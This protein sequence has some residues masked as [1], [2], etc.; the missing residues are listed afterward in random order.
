MH[1][2]TLLASLFVCL[3]IAI[4][5]GK[6]S[7]TPVS[8]SGSSSG[9]AGASADGSTLKATAPT[10]QS[11]T[12]GARVEGGVVLRIGN[13][14]AKFAT[15]PLS[16]RFQV[17]NEAGQRVYESG[18]IAAGNG[19][20]SHAVTATL[21]FN[22]RHTWRAR[23]EY[24]S[25]VGPW[26]Q[27]A[28]FVTPEGGYMR[29]SEV[30]DPL[31]NEKTVG[32]VHGFVTFVKGQGARIENT[33]SRISYQLPVTLQEGQFSFLATGVDE[34]NPC[35]KCKVMSM[36]EGHGDVTAND[37]RLSL[38]VRGK[39]YLTAP[40]AVAFRIIT[41]ESSNSGRIHDT[42]RRVVPFSRADTLFFKVWWENGRAGYEIRNGGPNGSMKDSAS[43]VT[44]GH[45]YRPTPHVI[46]VGSTPA[47]GGA[48]NA[49][50]PNMT[51]KNVWISGRPRPNF[52]DAFFTE[53]Q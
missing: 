43:V 50:H 44:D 11:P 4:G 2:K 35:V 33:L 41:G 32:K 13:A 28:E 46:H 26:S 30:L 40:G 10:A 3:T 19:S 53:P 31:T 15:V 20:T 27:S 25:A 6:D 39:N 16:Y 14:Q 21:D 37:Y 45:P 23:A 17:F 12:G 34:G 5:C 24:F 22:K 29:D 38:E 47:R 1:R 52:I 7:P 49:S 51:V 42:R 8:P 18:Q 36:A 48:G 9:D